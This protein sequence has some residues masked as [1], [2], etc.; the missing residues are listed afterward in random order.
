MQRIT[1]PAAVAVVV[2]LVLSACANPYDPGQRALG[3]AAIGAGAGAL[4]WRIARSALVRGLKDPKHYVA[5]ASASLDRGWGR[6]TQPIAGDGKHPVAIHFTWA[7]AVPVLP[8]PLPA[9]GPAPLTI[10]AEAEDT[11]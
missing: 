10:E 5:A 7:D 2:L 3:G 9:S 1:W 4:N 8:E 6:P 11:G